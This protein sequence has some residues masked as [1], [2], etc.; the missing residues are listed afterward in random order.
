MKVKRIIAFILCLSIMCSF[1]VSDVCGYERD[2]HDKYMLDV[3]FKNFKVVDNDPSIKD[4]IKA[5]E[6]ACYLTIDQFNSSGQSDLTFLND[7]GVKNIPSS[8]SEISFNASGTTHR[9]Y[10]HRGWSFTEYPL[11]MS[12]LWP[13]R[14]S[15][16]VNTVDTIFDFGGDEAKK[17]SFCILLYYI[18]LIG[19]HLDDESY[20]K[21]KKNGQKMDM[22]GRRDQYDITHELLDCLSTLF[23][24]QR[25]THKYLSLTMALQ[26]YNQ[27]YAQIVQSTGGVNS[28]EKFSLY[29]EYTKGLS[30]LLTYYLPEMLK[31]EPFFNSVFY[32]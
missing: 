17:E 26:R 12:D 16:L 11:I 15:I 10:T 14:K 28:E 18:H 25:N 13:I 21:L 2:E 8:I 20:E 3:L 9:S 27:K 23:K 24:D 29:K 1:H 22:G 32:S 30:K 5:L 19:D 31:D 4:I 7:F 6:C